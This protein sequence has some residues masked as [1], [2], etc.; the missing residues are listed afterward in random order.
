M[1]R[2]LAVLL[3]IAAPYSVAE[4]QPFTETKRLEQGTPPAGQGWSGYD[5]DISGDTAVGSSR[6]A[7]SSPQSPGGVS[8]F[9]RN[10][11]GPNNWGEV[12]EL[13]PNPGSYPDPLFAPTPR[14]VWRSTATR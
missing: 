12:K 10:L 4:G 8:V 1:G 9:E 2:F 3:F 7:F 13:I 11:G 14:A 6:D 5:V